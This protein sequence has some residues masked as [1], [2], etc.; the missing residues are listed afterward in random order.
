MNAWM[1]RGVPRIK[2]EEIPH[3]GRMAAI[4]MSMMRLP[5]IVFYHKGMS[6]M[7]PA[8]INRSG[9]YFTLTRIWYAF[10]PM[11]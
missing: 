9:A 3:Y 7:M 5:R 4:R 1:A 8:Q 2:S 6:T 11:R 10:I